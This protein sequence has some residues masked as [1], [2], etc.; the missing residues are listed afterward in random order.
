MSCCEGNASLCEC[1]PAGTAAGQ[2]LV[3][4]GTAWVPGLP[5][6]ATFGLLSWSQQW[7]VINFNGLTTSEMRPDVWSSAA[8]NNAD[9]NNIAFA[10]S[11]G[12]LRKITV[13]LIT[14]VLAIDMTFTVHLNGAATALLVLLPAGND[15]AEATISVPIAAA[16]ENLLK[17]KATCA[18]SP[19]AATVNVRVLT[20]GLVTP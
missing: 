14:A 3:W 8:N 15:S 4:N 20:L 7:G 9:G 5:N 18:V 2:I 17:V 1:I 10:R 11:G 16:D 12:A 19:G 13:E 6:V